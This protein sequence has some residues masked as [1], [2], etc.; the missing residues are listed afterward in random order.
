MKS[1]KIALIVAIVLIVFIILAVLLKNNQKS[2]FEPTDSRVYDAEYIIVGAGGAGCVLAGRLIEAG[3]K[4]LVL[5]AGPDTSNT[6]T[7]PN[8]QDDIPNIEIPINFPFLWNRYNRTQGSLN[9]GGWES[10]D[11]LL[12]LISENQYAGRYYAN[13]KGCGAGGSAA[14]NAMQDGRGD[15]MVYE[16]ISKELDDPIY[17][18]KNSEARFMKMENYTVAGAGP[19]HGTSGW[20]DVRS[21]DDIDNVQ[22]AFIDSAV[23]LGVPYKDD[24]SNGSKWEGVGPSNVA[25]APDGTRSHSFKDLLQPMLTANPTK[26]QVIFN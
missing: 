14:H 19:K 16:L 7:D 24:F 13:P 1:Q 9:C 17:N 4:V 22:Q 11:T 23:K 18:A 20:L 15:L 6:S 5:E 26:G 3:H 2:C 25:V 8:V 21:G 12:D 10:S